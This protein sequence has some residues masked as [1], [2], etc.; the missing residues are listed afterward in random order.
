[1]SR[2]RILYYIILFCELQNESF[3]MQFMKELL[4]ENILTFLTFDAV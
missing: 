2:T 1:M 4:I 3:L